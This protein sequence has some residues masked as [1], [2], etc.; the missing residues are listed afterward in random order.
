MRHLRPLCSVLTLALVLAH[1]PHF[2]HA[3]GAS[4]GGLA[5]APAAGAGAT[6]A[7]GAAAGP[8]LSAQSIASSVGGGS[9]GTVQTGGSPLP[10]TIWLHTLSFLQS[11][12]SSAAAVFST[13]Q[14]VES[15]GRRTLLMLLSDTCA[16]ISAT[17]ELTQS[18]TKPPLKA[19][20]ITVTPVAAP[21]AKPTPRGGLA[22]CTFNVKGTRESLTMVVD[23]AVSTTQ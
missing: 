17:P 11:A 12:L 8:E 13:G 10:C 7:A 20:P 6:P 9:L 16:G 21:P 19:V 14:S 18:I 4:A 2:T 22:T 23:A 15:A 3:Q 5:A 1:A